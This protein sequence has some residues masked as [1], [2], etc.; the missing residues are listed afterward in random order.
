M[1]THDVLILFGILTL[2]FGLFLAHQERIIDKQREIIDDYQKSLDNCID[3]Q[4]ELQLQFIKKTESI[5]TLKT[6]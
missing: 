3:Q 5:L 6:T 1:K 4:I 2:L